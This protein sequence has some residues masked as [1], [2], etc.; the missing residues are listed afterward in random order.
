M[1][2]LRLNRAVNTRLEWSS[3]MSDAASA[4]ACLLR[5]SDFKYLGTPALLS[6]DSGTSACA[7]YHWSCG[8]LPT[9]AAPC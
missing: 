7:S 8:R 2:N 6:V 4:A 1:V 3:A 9:E 5:L